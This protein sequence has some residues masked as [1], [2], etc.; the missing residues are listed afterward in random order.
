MTNSKQSA[1]VLTLGLVF[2][3]G[4]GLF[5]ENKQLRQ[6]A[7]AMWQKAHEVSAI[8]EPNMPPYDEQAVFNL[9]GVTAGQL[10]GSFIKDFV[11]ADTWLTQTKAG[12]YDGLSIRKDGRL[13][14]HEN[15]D[16]TPV[17][18]TA[19]RSAMTMAKISTEKDESVR[20][21]FAVTVDGISASCIQT[22]IE[23]SSLRER[24]VSCVSEQ[25]GT[26]VSDSRL[27]TTTRYLGYTQFHGKLVPTK[28]EILELGHKIVEAT[29]SYRD[30]P[31]LLA[32]SIQVPD[33]LQPEPECKLKTPPQLQFQMEPEPPRGVDFGFNGPRKVIVQILIGKDGRVS[34]SMVLQSSGAEFDKR[35]EEAVRKWRFKPSLCDGV[36]IEAKVEVEVSFWKP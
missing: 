20:K 33:G 12:Q 6:R 29:I 15:T 10:E 8:D 18:I 13:Y 14:T 21:I 22:E 25:D 3:S 5:A 36:P 1:V 31:K 16:F 7:E 27:N 35:S 34:K 9:E 11:N 24:N 32:A 23:H 26:L 2:L 4:T 28:L 19:L 30:Q 17:G